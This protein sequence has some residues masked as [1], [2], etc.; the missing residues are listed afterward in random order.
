VQIEKEKVRRT[1][2]VDKVVKG[3]N[4]FRLG[5]FSTEGI[6]ADELGKRFAKQ[7]VVICDDAFHLGTATP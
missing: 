6:A 4:A 3:R 7:R 2:A 5:D 1:L